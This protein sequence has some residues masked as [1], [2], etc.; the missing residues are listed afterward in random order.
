[1]VYRSP[2]TPAYQLPRSLLIPYFLPPKHSFLP[3]AD[4]ISL[5]VIRRGNYPISWQSRS[6]VA[7]AAAT[8][9]FGGYQE[10][11]G[12]DIGADIG[13]GA[14]ITLARAAR[15]GSLN[16]VIEVQLPSNYS[17]DGA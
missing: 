13:A 2:T 16:G 15:P 11:H 12:A 9:G 6:Q 8:R 5:M 7:G 14:G 17:A 10:A 1:M 3:L 4:H